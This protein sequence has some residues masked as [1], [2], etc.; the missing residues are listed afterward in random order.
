MK[1]LSTTLPKGRVVGTKFH[2]GFVGIPTDLSS[3][4]STCG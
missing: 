1:K 2:G 3:D 4:P